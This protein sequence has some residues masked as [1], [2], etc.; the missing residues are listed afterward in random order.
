MSVNCDI[1]AIFPIY[2]QF[3]A[4]REPDSRGIVYKTYIS[5]KNN[6]LFY[7]N[8]KNN[9]KI[10]NTA[11]ALLPWV[12]VLFLPKNADINN[13]PHPSTSKGP[14][15]KLTQIRVKRHFYRQQPGHPLI[16]DIFWRDKHRNQLMKENCCLMLRKCNMFLLT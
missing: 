10:S 16:F 6:I 1:I 2:G 15:K 7:K 4:I 11:H 14:P 12:K 8:W 5:I 3:G 9:Y 13:A